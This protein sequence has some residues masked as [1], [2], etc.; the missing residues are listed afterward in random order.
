ML[1]VLWL[2]IAG[3]SKLLKAVSLTLQLLQLLNILWIPV[4]H[5]LCKWEQ[6]WHQNL[7]FKTFYVNE[8]AEHSFHNG[9]FS[10]L[11]HNSYCLKIKILNERNLFKFFIWSSPQGSHF[12]VWSSLVSLLLVVFSWLIPTTY[13]LTVYFELNWKF[14]NWNV[15]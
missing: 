12:P 11:S 8:P 9:L 5:Y 1:V 15:A 2:L 14:G 10:L 4:L 7:I 3:S 13:C 6:R